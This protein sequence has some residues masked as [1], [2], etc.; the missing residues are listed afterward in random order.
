MSKRSTEREFLKGATIGGDKPFFLI[1][2][3]CVMESR[4]LLDQ[5]AE[6]MID[7]CKRLGIFYIFKS[8]FDKANRSSIHSY[9]GP[10]L[11]EGIKNLEYI[12]AF[13]WID[14]NKSIK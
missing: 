1:A 9:R 3:P 10:G 14:K 2:G 12:N 13:D 5:V 7:I 11:S 6:Q 4:E 8:S